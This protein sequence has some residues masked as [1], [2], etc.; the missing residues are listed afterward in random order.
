MAK[1][2]NT[3]PEFVLTEESIMVAAKRIGGPINAQDVLREYERIALQ[4]INAVLHESDEFSFLYNN[5]IRGATF[6]SN[7]TEKQQ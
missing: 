1:E 5:P 7:I 2:Y 3:E 4:V 6:I